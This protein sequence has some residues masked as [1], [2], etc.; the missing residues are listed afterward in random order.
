LRRTHARHGGP[1]DGFFHV[2]CIPL[3]RVSAPTTAA[4]VLYRQ[5]PLTGRALRVPGEEVPSEPRRVTGAEITQAAGWGAQHIDICM[6]LRVHRLQCN[7]AVTAWACLPMVIVAC[8]QSMTTPVADTLVTWC[9]RCQDP[10]LCKLTGTVAQH[11]SFPTLTTQPA[12]AAAP[13]PPAPPPAIR[14]GVLGYAGSSA[15]AV[16]AHMWMARHGLAPT[17]TSR[18]GV[19][20]PRELWR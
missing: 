8:L 12:A 7:A 13:P 6:G 9:A 10:L 20:S 17:T 19:H 3:M 1:I 11:S 14:H 5:P 15:H 4:V 16:T 18:V 2:S